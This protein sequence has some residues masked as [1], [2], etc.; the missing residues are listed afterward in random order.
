M[1]NFRELVLPVSRS[2]DCCDR[3]AGGLMV[4][5]VGR[6]ALRTHQAYGAFF[7]LFNTYR[8]PE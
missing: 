4:V 5:Q 3:L 8:Q 1:H 6:Q 2:I 7:A